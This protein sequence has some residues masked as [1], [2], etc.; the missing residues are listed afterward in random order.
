VEKLHT[1]ISEL[2]EEGK[3]SKFH[4]SFKETIEDVLSR[5]VNTGVVDLKQVGDN[6]YLRSASDS[7]LKIKQLFALFG[8]KVSSHTPRIIKAINDLKASPKL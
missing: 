6:F 3:I 1:V 4:T 2:H 7:E 5:F 8:S